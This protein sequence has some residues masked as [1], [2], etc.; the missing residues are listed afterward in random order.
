LVG[1]RWT[2]LRLFRHAMTKQILL[3]WKVLSLFL[4]YSSRGSAIERGE[5][6]LSDPFWEFHFPWSLPRNN[7]FRKRNG[8]RWLV[9]G[10]FHLEGMISKGV[11]HDIRQN[12]ASM[13]LQV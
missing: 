7:H 9:L 3:Q 13:S 8:M 4:E 2:G 5:E 1:V 6:A 11:G 12:H 10:L